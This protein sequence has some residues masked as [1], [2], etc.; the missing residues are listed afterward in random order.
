M[1]NKFYLEN[2]LAPYAKAPVEYPDAV[3]PV[4]IRYMKQQH[5]KIKKSPNLVDAWLLLLE[6]QIRVFYTILCQNK[7]KATVKHGTLEWSNKKEFPP[8]LTLH[9]WIDVEPY[10]IDYRGRTWYELNSEHQ[11]LI[12][13]VPYGVFIPSDFLFVSY[14]EAGVQQVTPIK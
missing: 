7:I 13:Q 1:I 11:P 12:E 5:K 14:R 4:L 10:R 9:L 3:D 2:L 8:T 6:G